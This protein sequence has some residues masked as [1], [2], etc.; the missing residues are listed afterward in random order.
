MLKVRFRCSIFLESILV[1]SV[2]LEV[3][4]FYLNYTI[5]LHVVLYSIPW[6]SFLFLWSY[7]CFVT[8]YKWLKCS[9]LVFLK[10]SLGKDLS[11]LLIFF[12]ELTFWFYWLSLLILYTLF[13]FFQGKSLIFCLFLLSQLLKLGKV[14]DLRYFLI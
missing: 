1:V 4:P 2:F 9:S 3:F 5:L 7:P 6:E 11:F 14:T 8:S 13:H 10:I 12:K